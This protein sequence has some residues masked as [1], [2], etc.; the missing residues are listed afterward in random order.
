MPVRRNEVEAAMNSG[1]HSH[2]LHLVITKINKI[3]VLRFLKC[4]QSK[5]WAEREREKKVRE[6]R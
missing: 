2:Y 5:S 3:E 6:E 1:C 4:F